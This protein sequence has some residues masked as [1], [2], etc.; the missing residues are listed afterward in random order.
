MVRAAVAFTDNSFLR[1]RCASRNWNTSNAWHEMNIRPP[2][3]SKMAIS[4][5]KYEQLCRLYIFAIQFC[6]RNNDFMK[7][8]K[9]I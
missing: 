2:I 6:L 9:L 3:F 1:T 5:Q 7:G 8:I 4:N